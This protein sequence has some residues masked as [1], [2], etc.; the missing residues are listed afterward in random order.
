MGS[1]EIGGAAAG[2]ASACA[3]GAVAGALTGADGA[4]L[5]DAAE[6]CRGEGSTIRGASGDEE[7]GG[8]A[9]AGAGAGVGEAV[10]EV[11]GR[12]GGT[13]GTT[14]PCAVADGRGEGGSW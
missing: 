14:G 9:G 10:G 12:G 7:A 13:S 8:V 1:G 6:G 2:A 4:G 3:V 11:A 5:G